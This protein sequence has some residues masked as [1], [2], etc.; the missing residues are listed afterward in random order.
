MRS[1]QQ[2]GTKKA[3]RS[4][5][6]AALICAVMRGKSW[7]GKAE[8]RVA[9]LICAVMRGKSWGQG[10]IEPP[11]SRTLSENHA[12][13]PLPRQLVS[14]GHGGRDLKACKTHRRN[15]PLGPKCRFR[16]GPRC[17]C[18]TD[19]WDC[20]QTTQ[21]WG[22]KTLTLR[23]PSHGVEQ[24]SRHGLPHPRDAFERAP[25][26]GSS[27]VGP[28]SVCAAPRVSARTRD[29]IVLNY[30]SCTVRI[31][32]NRWTATRG[33]R[34]TRGQTLQALKTRVQPGRIPYS[35]REKHEI[36]SRITRACL[37]C[38]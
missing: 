27:L 9:A 37:C 38:P 1:V 26:K 30:A 8:S 10:G 12:T 23:P 21:K 22:H 15:V 4:P 13:R 7:G 34:R 33:L 24:A 35:R 32:S 2:A 17:V 19:R 16:A 25:R 6:V 3:T 5:R 18:K 20:V 11:T 28:P 36:G 14:S 29:R 31:L